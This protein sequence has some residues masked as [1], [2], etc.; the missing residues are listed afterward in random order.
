MSC[1]PGYRA[2]DDNSKLPLL[3]DAEGR[4]AAISPESRRQS[5][6]PLLAAAACG[7]GPAWRL[8]RLRPVH[9]SVGILACFAVCLAVCAPLVS[10]LVREVATGGATAS[11]TS[12]RPRSRHQPPAVAVTRLLSL[13]H[14]CDLAVPGNSSG[15]LRC[16][17]E[18]PDCAA[19]PALCRF[20]PAMLLCQ[21]ATPVCLAACLALL[22]LAGFA[23]RQF[24]V[25][26][27]L[28][29]AAFACASIAL[30]ATV[31]FVACLHVLVG[32]LTAATTTS[33]G[34][35]GLAYSADTA[36][37]RLAY[38]AICLQ[39]VLAFQLLCLPACLAR[40]GAE[41][42]DLLAKLLG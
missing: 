38:A 13:G 15:G 41:R 8:K 12:S 37:A 39:A 7:G 29:F 33:G 1:S 24:A 5:L 34:S 42:A 30:L 35:G 6:P 18:P 28:L 36:G 4:D 27:R 20:R 14:H 32:E 10:D 9:L 19:L 23:A 2:D 26:R 21:A 3:A 40:V 16:A 11:S 31:A 25:Q 17:S 22:A